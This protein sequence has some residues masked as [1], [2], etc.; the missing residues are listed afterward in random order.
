MYKTIAV[1]ALLVAVFAFVSGSRSADASATATISAPIVARGEVLNQSTPIPTTTIFTPTQTGLFRLSVYAYLSTSDVSSNQGWNY[2]LNWTDGA[3]AESSNNILD[4]N[5]NQ[6]PPLAWAS[7]GE[8]QNSPGCVTVF[9]AVAN[10]PV[11]YS[12]F[13][14][15][16]NSAVSVYWI[17]E[18]LE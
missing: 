5:S 15:P 11:T 12:F 10:S 9:E 2:T 8:T 18:R 3:G 4:V 13:K 7:V 1:A 16:D 17:V 14:N 6:T